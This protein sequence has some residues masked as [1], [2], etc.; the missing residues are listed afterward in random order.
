MDRP[1]KNIE[2]KNEKK[3]ENK[4]E[5][6]YQLKKTSDCIEIDPPGLGR[7]LKKKSKKVTKKRK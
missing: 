2:K 4:I 1:K 5:A 3:S 6:I 7:N